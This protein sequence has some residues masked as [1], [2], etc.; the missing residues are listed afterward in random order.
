MRNGSADPTCCCSLRLMAALHATN[1]TGIATAAT[2]STAIS[3]VCA[4][5]RRMSKV[6]YVIKLTG[7]TLVE[8]ARDDGPHVG[9]AFAETAH[10][11]REPLAAE[12]D[13]DADARAAGDER[14]LKIPADAVEQLELVLV[15]AD[16]PFLRPRQRQRVHRRIVR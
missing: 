8:Q 2:P 12:R 13:V 5:R 14:L 6:F 3:T 7:R 4:V 11:V 16:A 1:S 10:E 15:P 9:R